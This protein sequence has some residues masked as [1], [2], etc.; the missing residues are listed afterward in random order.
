M[1]RNAFD[2]RASALEDEFFH[3]V[4]QELIAKL[5]EQ[6][7]LE[8]DEEALTHATGIT[9][10][11]VL[12]ELIQVRITPRS[13]TALSLFPAIY[14]AWASGRVQTSERRAVR[15]VM[16]QMGIISGSPTFEL[17]HAWLDRKPSAELVQAWKDFIHAIRPTMSAAA[18]REMHDAAIKRARKIADAASGL[19]GLHL[20]SKA[21]E[22][23]I[24][25][26]EAVFA[27]ATVDAP[28]APEA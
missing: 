7:Q 21:E 19:L 14:V 17:L 12:D 18:F 16:E 9:D 24:T 15:E 22:V 3:R 1:P 26:L 10:K 6:H 28:S 11:T 5:Q 13:L 27:D 25:E 4:D 23:A 20:I 8:V 2:R